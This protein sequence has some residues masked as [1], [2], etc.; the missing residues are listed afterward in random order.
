MVPELA[1]AIPPSTIAEIIREIASTVAPHRGLNERYIHHAFSHRVQS[2][3][4]C[5][6]LSAPHHTLLFHPEW[7]TFKKSTRL[8]YAKYHKVNA[9]ISQKTLTGM[10]AEQVLL[11]LLSVPRRNRKLEWNFASSTAGR[12]KT[13][14]TTSSRFSILGIRFAS[15]SRKPAETDG[16]VSGPSGAAA[17]LRI[18]ASSLDGLAREL[19]T[20]S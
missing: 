8:R 16:R 1:A 9:A 14:S 17:K 11:T 13:L 7:P 4:P 20:G 10:S 12:M 2:V 15:V 6:D 5:L 3:F 18:Q 19:T